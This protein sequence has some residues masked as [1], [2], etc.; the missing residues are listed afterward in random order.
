[1]IT[2][3]GVRAGEVIASVPHGISRYGSLGQ[4]L[5][6]VAHSLTQSANETIV[7]FLRL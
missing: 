1:M 2:T 5:P 6:A 7:V 3:Q 4:L